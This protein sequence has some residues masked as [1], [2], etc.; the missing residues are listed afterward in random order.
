MN[1]VI[2]DDLKRT[3]GS[4]PGTNSLE[5]PVHACGLFFYT[6][7]NFVI[8]RPLGLAQ[9]RHN[10]VMTTSPGTLVYWGFV[11]SQFAYR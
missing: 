3:T 9:L 8:N 6:R 5:L 7:Y 10:A 1:V 2:Y 11:P 4:L